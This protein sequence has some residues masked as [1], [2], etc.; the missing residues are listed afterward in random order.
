MLLQVLPDGLRIPA[1]PIP[2]ASLRKSCIMGP[3][4]Q[5][6]VVPVLKQGLAVN[7]QKLF[8]PLDGDPSWIFGHGVENAYHNKVTVFGGSSRFLRSA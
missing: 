8:S 6:A 4:L 3:E 5:G 1:I 7:A 2:G